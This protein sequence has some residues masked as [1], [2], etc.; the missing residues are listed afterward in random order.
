MNDALQNETVKTVN[1]I[2]RHPNFDATTLDND[3]AILNIQPFKWSNDV[4][5]LTAMDKPTDSTVCEVI[6][7]GENENSE[8]FLQKIMATIIDEANCVR[9][10]GNNSTNKLCVQGQNGSCIEEPGSGL[11]CDDELTGIL[12]FGNVCG[13]MV[14]TDL[15][16]YNVWID[17][18]F[19]TAI[20]KRDD[21]SEQTA[22]GHSLESGSTTS[23]TIKTTVT[24]SR[25]TEAYEPQSY[26]SPSV[27]NQ[28]SIPPTPVTPSENNGHWYV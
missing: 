2:L 3:V 16:K 27:T 13:Q 25:P 4:E 26:T 18:V 12:S 15:T 20:A 1:Q 7:W 24:T 9:Q 21:D 11:V 10:Y 5:M 8:P 28:D 6:G 17:E 23:T 14:Y 22:L 19:R